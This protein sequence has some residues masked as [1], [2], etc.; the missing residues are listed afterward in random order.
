MTPEPSHLPFSLEPGMALQQVQSMQRVSDVNRCAV[1]YSLSDS[2]PMSTSTNTLDGPYTT[3][4]RRG[5]VETGCLDQYGWRDSLC[6]QLRDPLDDGQRHHRR[7][8]VMADVRDVGGAV[9]PGWGGDLGRSTLHGACEQ[10]H[11]AG[12]C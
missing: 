7:R 11:L 9:H 12:D 6:A 2:P 10:G 8:R 4:W 3:I 1:S 5:A